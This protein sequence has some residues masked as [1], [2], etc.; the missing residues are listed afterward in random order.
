MRK[1][2]TPPA[3][4]NQAFTLASIVLSNARDQLLHKLSSD[5]Y[6]TE[7]DKLKQLASLGSVT[8]AYYELDALAPAVDEL[9]RTCARLKPTPSAPR[10]VLDMLDLAIPKLSAIARET[11]RLLPEL[12][13][14]IAQYRAS[15]ELTSDTSE[16]RS[17][18]ARKSMRHL[19]PA[20]KAQQVAT[21]RAH[22]TDAAAMLDQLP[23]TLAQLREIV[24]GGGELRPTSAWLK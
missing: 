5:S 8:T 18:F 7:A 9:R 12:A 23:H 15:Q 19:T 4:L 22:A 11:V 10:T 21:A 14:E 6:T 24:K 16:R 1:S 3:T 2:L 13:A 17:R 20:E